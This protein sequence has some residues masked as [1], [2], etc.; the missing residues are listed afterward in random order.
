MAKSEVWGM[1]HRE[2]AALADDLAQLAPEQWEAP[3][4]CDGWSVRDVVAHMTASAM[5]TPPKFF[6]KIVGS[7]F[8]LSRMQGKDIARER[9]SSSADALARFRAQINSTKHPPGPTDAWLGEALIHGED[10]RR[11]LG[12][13][14]EYEKDAAVRVAEF[15]KG[16]NLIV[17]AKKRIAGLHLEASDADWAHG[18]GPKVSG[19]VMSLVMAMTGRKPALADLTGDGVATLAQRG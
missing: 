12:I 7:G 14:H 15:Y 9:G 4:Q 10:I 6:A 1:I 2:R 19:P 18:D 3:S 11:P 16:S 13:A 17:G 8:S 5:I